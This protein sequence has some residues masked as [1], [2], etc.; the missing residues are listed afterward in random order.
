MMADITDGHATIQPFRIEENLRRSVDDLS[1]YYLLG[2][3]TNGKADGR[4]HRITVRVKRPGVQV[5]ARS[6][7]LAATAAEA[8][9]RVSSAV[10]SPDA[11]EARLVAQALNPLAALGRERPIRVQAAVAWTPARAATARR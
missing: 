3:Y 5:R 10:S 9:S 2:Y 11:A 1:S 4:Y 7:Y 8:A 6:G